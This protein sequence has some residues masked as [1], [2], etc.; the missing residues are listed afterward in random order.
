MFDSI[1]EITEDILHTQRNKLIKTFHSDNG[2][3]NTKYAQKINEAYNILLKEEKKK[4][5]SP[6]LSES[7]CPKCQ[8][9]MYIIGDLYHCKTCNKRFKKQS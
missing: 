7:K 1:D 8:N 9:Y 2:E 6:K 4:A 5:A 3:E